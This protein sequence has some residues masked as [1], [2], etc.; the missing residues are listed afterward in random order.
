MDHY[1]SKKENREKYRKRLYSLLHDDEPLILHGAF[2]AQRYSGDDEKDELA[3]EL[4]HL[5][6]KIISGEVLCHWATLNEVEE[7]IR[8]I[9]GLSYDFEFE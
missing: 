2:Y 5:S 4:K 9:Y 6:R 8:R 1:L 3:E 7:A